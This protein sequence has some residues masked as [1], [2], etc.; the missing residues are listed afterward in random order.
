MKLGRLVIV[1][2]SSGKLRLLEAGWWTLRRGYLIWRLRPNFAR[3]RFQYPAASP[4]ATA[5][6][7]IWVARDWTRRYDRVLRR[8]RRSSR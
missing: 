6:E 4:P 7:A 5:Q 8:F 1:S 2:R 3:P